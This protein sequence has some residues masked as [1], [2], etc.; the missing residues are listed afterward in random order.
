MC[1]EWTRVMSFASDDTLDVAKNGGKEQWMTR[2]LTVAQ[3]CWFSGAHQLS[4]WESSP[5]VTLFY[6]LTHYSF[7]RRMLSQL[8]CSISYAPTDA[9]ASEK[10][11]HNEIDHDN[12]SFLSRPCRFQKFYF[13][14]HKKNLG[15]VI[16]YPFT[17]SFKSWL[18]FPIGLLL[19]VHNGCRSVTLSLLWWTR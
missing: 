11:G 14:V 16:Q 19:W 17:H 13:L 1:S 2:L 5:N 9:S 6:P 8:Q 4:G 7:S 18:T 10:Q 15:F 3:L 12:H